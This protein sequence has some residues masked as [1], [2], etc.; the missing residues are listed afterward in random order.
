MLHKYLHE[1]LTLECANPNI[2]FSYEAKSYKGA[3][4]YPD[5]KIKAYV[6]AGLMKQIP[7]YIAP[8]YKR[9]QFL[10]QVTKKGANLIGRR[11]EYKQKDARSYNNLP[12]WMMMLSIRL[13]FERLFPDWIITSEYEKRFRSGV[14]ENGKERFF[15]ADIFIKA[16]RQDLQEERFFI[17]ETEHKDIRRTYEEKIEKYD[18]YLSAGF[19][20]LNKLSEN[21]KILIVSCTNEYPTFTIPQEYDNVEVKRRLNA[22]YKQFNALLYRISKHNNRYYRLMAFPDFHRMNEAVWYMPNRNTTKILE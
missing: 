16:V 17:I 9:R 13:A 7:F 20:K 11:D 5:K 18:R 3:V 1:T 22:L 6:K 14:M 8:P 15:K 12:H 19:L 4:L 21:T 2:L 10:Y